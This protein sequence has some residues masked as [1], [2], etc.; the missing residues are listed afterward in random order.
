GTAAAL[1]IPADIVAFHESQL[2][3]HADAAL[4]KTFHSQWLARGGAVPSPKQCIGYR[5]PLF[6]GGNDVLDNLEL[7]DIDVYWTLSAQLIEQSRHLPP[8]SKIR[9]TRID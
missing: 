9:G 2:V 5:R 1:E 7:T 6:L 3:N 8:G 4:A